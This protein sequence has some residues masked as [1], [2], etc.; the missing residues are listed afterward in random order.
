VGSGVIKT[1]DEG[2]YEFS[3]CEIHDNN[4]YY[5]S[6]SELFSSPS[7]TS[8][9]SNCSIYNNQ[10]YDKDQIESEILT[11]GKYS[12][13]TFNID[14]IH[15]SYTTYLTDNPYL[16]T[17]S[18]VI[19]SI[20]AIAA[21][22]ILDNNTTIKN[23]DY[24]M[25]TIDSVIEIDEIIIEN[26]NA[27]QPT[28]EIAQSTFKMS[29]STITNYSSSLTNTQLLRLSTSEF[30]L[31]DVAYSNSNVSF[32]LSTY[33]T[34][35]MNQITLDQISSYQPV[36]LFYSSDL[37]MTNSNLNSVSSNSGSII[38]T[39]KSTISAINSLT[40]TN[41]EQIA[42][43]FGSTNI[44][45]IDNLSIENSTVGLRMD[46]CNADSIINSNFKTCGTVDNINGAAIYAQFTNFTLQDS[47]FDS[48]KAN[49]G[50]AVT[51]SCSIVDQ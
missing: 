7:F 17:Q 42:L 34:A 40:I 2:Y 22:I 26:I 39:Q 47:T 44:A 18:R 23:Q 16:L 10:V 11:K 1:N 25:N 32:I 24:F 5:T 31:D 45:E 14:F 6:V 8:K 37:S 36:M 30:E 3:N 4:A 33:S 13:I 48:N 50:P 28:F 46:N 19:S 29:H 20:Q 41:T 43:D 21:N 38:R 51:I 12:I 9:M 49:D 27:T 15:E 35:T